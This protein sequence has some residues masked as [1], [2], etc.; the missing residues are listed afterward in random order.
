[1]KLLVHKKKKC[2]VGCLYE[3]D[4]NFSKYQT[5]GLYEPIPLDEIEDYFVEEKA[6]GFI[7]VIERGISYKNAYI[8]DCYTTR[9]EAESAA[10]VLFL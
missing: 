6:N 2:V 3:T 1:M 9:T 7:L 8:V 4:E 5:N 10:K